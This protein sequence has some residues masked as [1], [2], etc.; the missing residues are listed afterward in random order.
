MDVSIVIVNH[1]TFKLTCDC[2]RS[3]LQNTDGIRYEV[4]LVDNRSDECDPD[5]FLKIFPNIILVKSHINKG[6]AGG[7]NL[8]IQ[9]A[10]G[11]NILLLNSDTVLIENSIKFIFDK[12]K[13]IEDIGAA[14]IRLVYPNGKIQ[15]GAQN[16]YSL[17]AHFLFTTRL[18][19][20]F[21]GLYQKKRGVFDFTSDFTADWIWGTFFYFPKKNLQCMGG[22]LS[23]T[24][25][26]YS[27]DVEWC[28]YFKKNA[29]N[30]YYFGGSSI[31]HLG[32]QSSSKIF[33]NKMMSK[34][35]LNFIKRK[36]GLL[37]CI[38]EKILLTLD[39]WEWKIRSGF[40]EK[41]SKT[42]L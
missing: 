10:A 4:I 6:F 2:I 13:N 42:G 1:N 16:F 17:T 37:K 18:Y 24:Y 30:N 28:Y 22:K 35:H 7:N 32:G 3:I 8:G 29:L 20:V 26:M 27:E 19:K 34:N 23:E 5:D 11:D 39:E 25:F 21:K 33:K 38:A 36:D 31:V 14:T 15:H 12:C 40:K 9:M 41:I